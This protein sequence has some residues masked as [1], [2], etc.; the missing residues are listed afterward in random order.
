MK[1]K[2]KYCLLSLIIAVIGG[3]LLMVAAYCLPIDVI[4]KNVSHSMSVFFDR[5]DS[6]GGFQYLQVDRFTDSLMVN[7]AIDRGTGNPFKDAVL[8]TR[9]LYPEKSS[10]ESLVKSLLVEDTDMAHEEIYSRYWHGYLVFLKLALMVSHVQGIYM[11]NIC[12]QLFLTVTLALKMVEVMGKKNMYAWLY[13]LFILNPV[14]MAICFQYGA[15]FYVTTITL[16]YIL[17]HASQMKDT[18]RI[19]K[20]MLWAGI[21]MSYL[22]LLTSPIVTWGFPLLIIIT[23]NHSSLRERVKE[24][25]I[26]SFAWGIGFAGMWMS[27]WI[28]ATIVRKEAALQDVMKSVVGYTSNRPENGQG[29]FDGMIANIHFL[30]NK[31]VL[32]TVIIG[33]CIIMAWV[34]RDKLVFDL[35]ASAL[36][37]L[38]FVAATLLWFI[39]INGHASIHYFMTYRNMT[40]AIFAVELM[41]LES[42]KRKE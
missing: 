33:V 29:R 10:T 11:I 1:T 17:T 8:N 26:G 12:I 9:L 34:V 32:L 25:F 15:T 38:L 7:T 30:S 22:D 16:L 6:T 14:S 27:K 40:V 2:A 37:Y 39:I 35:Q 3:Y 31:A 36:V 28:L 42:W 18:N 20:V 4:R 13:T 5:T 41:I 19:W 23:L 21:A 24:F